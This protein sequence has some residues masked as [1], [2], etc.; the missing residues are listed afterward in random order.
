MTQLS[1]ATVVVEVLSPKT[2]ATDYLVKPGDYASVATI[3]VYLIV[4]PDAPRIDVL[5]RT[6]LGL[7]LAEQAVGLEAI[8]DLPVIGAQLALSEIYPT[9]AA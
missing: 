4:D 7:E 6:D 5:R 9:S 1:E 3:A 2:R 8:N